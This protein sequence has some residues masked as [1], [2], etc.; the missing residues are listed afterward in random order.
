MFE[1]AIIQSVLLCQ[2]EDG[3][4]HDFWLKQPKIMLISLAPNPSIGV[5]ASFARYT[6]S[7]HEPRLAE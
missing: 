3:Q 5:V 7:R 2:F 6:A 4:V 1:S